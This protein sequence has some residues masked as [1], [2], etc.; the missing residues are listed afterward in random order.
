MGR[1]QPKARALS[2]ADRPPFCEYAGGMPDGSHDAFVSFLRYL[3]QVHGPP[4]N[5]PTQRDHLGKDYRAFRRDHQEAILP[6]YC[7]TLYRLS[8][9][10]RVLRVKKNVIIIW[11][12]QEVMPYIAPPPPVGTPR[13]D[14]VI[15]VLIDLLSA[16]HGRW[17][18]CSYL[19]AE[20]HRCLHVSRDILNEFGG[21]C[22]FL[23]RYPNEFEVD[24]TKGPY[25]A[26]RLRNRPSSPL[27]KRPR[28]DGFDS[29]RREACVGYSAEEFDTGPSSPPRLPQAPCTPSSIFEDFLLFLRLRGFPQTYPALE[30][31]FKE[32]VTERCEGRGPGFRDM[33]RLLCHSKQVVREDAAA[34]ELIWNK[35]ERAKYL[36][37]G[38]RPP[39][40]DIPP[41]LDEDPA[42]SVLYS[43]SMDLLKLC[44]FCSPTNLEISF[45]D[46]HSL[47][48]KLLASKP[49]SESRDPEFQEVLDLLKDNGVFSRVHMSGATL[50]KEG[51]QRVQMLG[52]QA[53]TLPPHGGP[54][55]PPTTYLPED[56]LAAPY[57]AGESQS[58]P[59]VRPPR[60]DASPMDGLDIRR[61]ATTAPA[62]PAAP[63]V[64]APDESACA[65][66]SP[67]RLQRAVVPSSPGIDT[68]RFSPEQPEAVRS[69][70][71][72]DP[73]RISLDH[74]ENA[75]DTHPIVPFGHSPEPEDDGPSPP[76]FDTTQFSPEQPEA[77]CR[78]HALP[79][80][81]P[82]RRKTVVEDA[83]LAQ[84]ELLRS[85]ED[86]RESRPADQPPAPATAPKE[87]PISLTGGNSRREVGPSAEPSDGASAENLEEGNV[88]SIKTVKKA[89]LA[90]QMARDMSAYM[91]EASDPRDVL[92]KVRECHRHVASAAGD[93]AAERS[94]KGASMDD[95]GVIEL[96]SE[97][98]YLVCSILDELE[99]LPVFSQ[100]SSTSSG[101]A[102]AS[103]SG[104]PAT[105]SSSGPPATASAT[106]A[107]ATTGTPTTVTPTS[108]ATTF[109]TH[110]PSTALSARL[111]AASVPTCA[112]TPSASLATSFSSTS[113]AASTVAPASLA[114]NP[115][116]AP[117]PAVTTSHTLPSTTAHTHK[118]TTPTDQSK[119]GQHGTVAPRSLARPPSQGAP[120]TVP[121]P[122]PR[123][124]RL[125]SLRQG[126]ASQPIL[127]ATPTPA[128][129]PPASTQ[130]T[131]D[132]VANEQSQ[133][134]GKVVKGR[135]ARRTIDD[136]AKVNGP[137]KQHTS[138]RVVGVPAGNKS[139][140]C[141]E[142]E[143]EIKTEEVDC[144]SSSR[145]AAREAL[146]VVENTT[147]VKVKVESG[148]QGHK[149]TAKLKTVGKR[150]KGNRTGS[151]SSKVEN[152]GRSKKVSAAS[153]K[154]TAAT[155]GATDPG[156][157]TG[158]ERSGETTKLDKRIEQTGQRKKCPKGAGKKGMGVADIGPVGCKETV[159][160]TDQTIIAGTEH[161]EVG[162]ERSAAP[163]TA[164][165]EKV[166]TTTTGVCATTRSGAR[167]H[168]AL[169]KTPASPKYGTH[170]LSTD[171]AHGSSRNNTESFAAAKA[172]V[173]LN[174]SRNAD[175]AQSKDAGESSRDS[176]TDTDSVSVPNTP[177]AKRARGEAQGSHTN[178]DSGS[179]PKL[180]TTSEA[181]RARG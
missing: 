159:K 85:S 67:R 86:A 60:T 13:T 138:E 117:P 134:G 96:L 116:A 29:R 43:R 94:R 53:A 33:W 72:N 92:R 4:R 99:S 73:P 46:L 7:D 23:Q 42:S 12:E 171:A 54:P 144:S 104:P 175:V 169:S 133:A 107:M 5:W 137:Q 77:T 17:V 9:V 70:R 111:S 14:D 10:Y 38:T 162:K 176:R 1:G 110:T 126:Q 181:K 130:P 61:R 81:P 16:K 3:K 147:D 79:P 58:N 66:T 32:F 87:M 173:A 90:A 22:R 49:S 174:R 160:N 142:D 139:G 163:T 103:S 8:K 132:A 153:K 20:A 155:H 27:R 105:A 149:E 47:Y 36:E 102:T 30:G 69:P 108:S 165:T 56:P 51:M 168:P 82:G 91:K 84:G 62:A 2:S 24:E 118:S 164:H 167:S 18:S 75:A 63:A 135:D 113:A 156:G 48:N 39:G 131:G 109:V 40:Y 123:D 154:K 26:A 21:C 68:S 152:V 143:V 150:L 19:E 140:H 101:P 119:Q 127:P 98:E 122:L 34:G 170:V 136:S 161:K 100:S 15:N 95:R 57:F 151:V 166:Q 128:S 71:P 178:A 52:F 112:S 65:T 88:L 145:H 80:L 76:P 97:S 172:D 158:A 41:F 106:S 114:P 115:P 28:G 177:E 179:V 59:P 157:V 6:A 125:Q 146:K 129:G 45:T 35:A 93:V 64:P 50:S 78:V 141:D 120:E 89:M 31:L 11:F 180:V 83:E 44:N 55:P 121:L 74:S 37:A 148:K 124:P 25:G